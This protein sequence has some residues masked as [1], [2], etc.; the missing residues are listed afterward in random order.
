[1]SSPPLLLSHPLSRQLSIPM[2]HKYIKSG[3]CAHYFF[4]FLSRRFLNISNYTHILLS[5]AGCFSFY[6]IVALWFQHHHALTPMLAPRL[7]YRHHHHRPPMMA[8]WFTA[9]FIHIK[10]A[11]T[12]KGKD[13]INAPIAKRV[14]PSQV[15][16]NHT[17]IHTQAKSHLYAIC[18]LPGYA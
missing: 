16:C 3:K 5:A 4:L 8:L 11:V 2:M 15:H 17:F 9:P 1:M 6:Y 13:F 14:L 10:A 7:Q 12:T 18:E